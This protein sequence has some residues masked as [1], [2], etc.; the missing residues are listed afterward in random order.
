VLSQRNSHAGRSIR[1]NPTAQGEHLCRD[2][3]EG[4]D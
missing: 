3:C 1:E 2:P 4:V